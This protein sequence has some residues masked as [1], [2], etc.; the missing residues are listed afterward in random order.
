MKRTHFHKDGCYY[1]QDFKH[2]FLQLAG[3][4]PSMSSGK[5]V[6][7]WSN[8]DSEKLD[9]NLT[10]KICLFSRFTENRQTSTLELWDLPSALKLPSWC[11]PQSIL[12]FLEI[13]SFDS[14]Q[15]KTNLQKKKNTIIWHSIMC[16]K[17]KQQNVFESVF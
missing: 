16:N 12:C 9:L 1:Q 4:W 17:C 14:K 11:L 5:Y 6:P 2:H 10:Q 8:N 13:E 7:K 3:K 15:A